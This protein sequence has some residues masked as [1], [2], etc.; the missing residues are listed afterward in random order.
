[1]VHAKIFFKVEGLKEGEI[2]Q[3]DMDAIKKKV[4]EINFFNLKDVYDNLK[5]QDI[6]STYVSVNNDTITKKIKSRYGSPTGLIELQEMLDKIV[7][8]VEWN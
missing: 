7:N 4:E 8:S 6:P 3:S 2:S 1:M 5:V